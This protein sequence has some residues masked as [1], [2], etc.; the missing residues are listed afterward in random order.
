[1]NKKQ[2]Y[3]FRNTTIGKMKMDMTRDEYSVIDF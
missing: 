2:E 1:M 3:K